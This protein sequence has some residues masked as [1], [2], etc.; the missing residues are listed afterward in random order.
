MIEENLLSPV[1]LESLI[2]DLLYLWLAN[3]LHL[4]RQVQFRFSD[5]R[6]G[7]Q[8]HNFKI[9]ANRYIVVSV[10]VYFIV[11]GQNKTTEEIC[12]IVNNLEYVRRSLAE[13]DDEHM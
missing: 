7:M 11:V 3:I 12:T 8:L 1:L 4:R 13:Y 10:N 6:S 2:I 5:N 9:C